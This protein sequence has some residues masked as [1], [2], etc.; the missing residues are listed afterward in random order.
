MG[1]DR[2]VRMTDQ[3]HRGHRLVREDVGVKRQSDVCGG[4]TCGLMITSD[5]GECRA[6]SNGSG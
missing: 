2:I 6:V 4:R 5:V 1:A 3:R